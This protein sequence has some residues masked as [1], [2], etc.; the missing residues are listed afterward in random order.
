MKLTLY[1]SPTNTPRGFHVAMTWKRSFP[2]HFNVE[3]TWSVCRKVSKSQSY[4]NEFEKLM[5]SETYR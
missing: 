4:A 3:S 5:F 2:R 1:A